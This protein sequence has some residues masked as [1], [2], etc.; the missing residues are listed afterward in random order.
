MFA[1]ADARPE[2]D[3]GADL[4]QDL[5]P[6]MTTKEDDLIIL[7]DGI[8]QRRKGNDD[9]DNDDDDDVPECEPGDI[10]CSPGLGGGCCH[11]SFPVCC[12]NGITCH[13]FGPC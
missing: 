6:P 5:Q 3:N 2:M 10:Q 13:T 1:L 7:G 12:G 9:D 8:A 11:P 4:P